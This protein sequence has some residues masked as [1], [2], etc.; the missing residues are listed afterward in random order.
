[1]ILVSP[2]TLHRYEQH[3]QH[4]ALATNL[5]VSELDKEMEKI[6]ASKLDDKSKLTLYQQVLQRYLRFTQHP[7]PPEN[8]TITTLEVSVLLIPAVLNTV[9]VQR[10]DACTTNTYIVAVP[11]EEETEKGGRK[12]VAAIPSLMDRL[13]DI[14]YDPSHSAGS[15]LDMKSSSNHLPPSDLDATKELTPL[16]DDGEDSGTTVVV[17]KVVTYAVVPPDGG[18]GWVIV[19]AS[20]FCNLIV[21]GIIFTFGMFL[22]DIQRE[23]G[24]SKS[25]V[26][27]VGSLLAGFYLMAGPF[28]S[29]LANRYGFRLV[30]ILGSIL[31]T[32]GFLASSFATDNQHNYG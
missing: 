28:V 6:F 25:K 20:F 3:H 17:Q 26:T 8:T 16:K 10:S 30:T 7:P 15:S 13:A 11:Y 12:Q 9:L 29:A 5:V 1:M 23:F 27:I 2:E 14:Y 4:V 19:T 24:A 18:W 22:K 21:D 31:G 32:V